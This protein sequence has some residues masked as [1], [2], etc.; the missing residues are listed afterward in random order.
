MYTRDLADPD[1]HM[2]GIFWMDPAAIPPAQQ[3]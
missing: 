3:R 2:W 1:G